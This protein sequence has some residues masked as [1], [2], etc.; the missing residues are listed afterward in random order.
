MPNTWHFRVPYNLH[1]CNK[2]PLQNYEYVQRLS[3][4]TYKGDAFACHG[5]ERKIAQI[6]E[7]PCYTNLPVCSFFWFPSFLVLNFRC[8]KTKQNEANRRK[9]SLLLQVVS[10][11]WCQS[12]YQW[13]GLLVPPSPSVSSLPPSDWP[14]AAGGGNSCSCSFTR[15]HYEMS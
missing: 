13:K 2:H 15:M 9:H 14:F 5:V 10:F 11:L 3:E 8:K 6:S 4:R 1:N 7:P 12:C